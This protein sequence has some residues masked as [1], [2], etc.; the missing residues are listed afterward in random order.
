MYRYV[1]LCITLLFT[2]AVVAQQP[3]MSPPPPP[4]DPGS[5]TPPPQMTVR[6][7]LDFQR[8]QQEADDLARTAQTI[9]ADVI[10]VRKGMLPKDV[11]LKL[12]QIEKL[13][14]R[15]RSELNP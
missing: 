12:K 7:N 8:M 6:L 11:I 15:L 4:L 9:P 14:K 10:S 1:V 2:I 5:A 3:K 13:S